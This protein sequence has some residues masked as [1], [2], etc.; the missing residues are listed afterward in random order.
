MT[1]KTD[2]PYPSRTAD[3]FVV[4][5]PDGMRDRI[6]EAAKDNARSMN[7]E[8]VARLDAS[9]DPAVPSRK[10]EMAIGFLTGTISGARIMLQAAIDSLAKKPDCQD[11]ADWLRKTDRALYQVFDPTPQEKE[12]FPEIDEI[13]PKELKD[14]LIQREEESKQEQQQSKPADAPVRRLKTDRYKEK[15]D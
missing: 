3:Q 1:S 14:M 15:K 12:R 8:I 6:A 5:L 13:L 9:F 7:A 11:E 2:K 4:R 10:H